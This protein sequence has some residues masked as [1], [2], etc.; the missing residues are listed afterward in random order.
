MHAAS[1]QTLV[2]AVPVLMKTIETAFVESG[3]AQTLVQFAVLPWHA[4]MS[5]P[6]TREPALPIGSWL[7]AMTF[8]FEY[9]ARVSSVM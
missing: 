6:A 8:L 2:A 3:L 1:Q 4:D 5:P 7:T 9:V